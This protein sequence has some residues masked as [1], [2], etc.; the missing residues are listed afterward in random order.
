MADI[1]AAQNGKL[2]V[3]ASGV[4]PNSMKD[5]P[6]LSV[7]DNTAKIAVSAFNYYI[8]A[9]LVEADASTGIAVGSG[10]ISAAKYATIRLEI[11][12]AGTLTAGTKSSSH[13]TAAQA[14]AD[15]TDVTTDK[16]SVGY[17]LIKSATSTVTTLGT[18]NLSE[19]AAA[20][21]TA[22]ITFYEEFDRS[23]V[24]DFRGQVSMTNSVTTV[25]WVGQDIVPS[26][27]IATGMD[28]ELNISEMI[29]RPDSLRKF[30][31]AV[32]N[33]ADT[34]KGGGD[35]YSWEVNADLRP[36]PLQLLFD[37]TDSETGLRKQIYCPQGKAMQIPMT[38]GS[39]DFVVHDVG[40]KL[41]IDSNR[42]FFYFYQA[43]A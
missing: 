36:V 27:S 43:K 21:A 3:A 17:Y 33:P 10:T 42:K 8:D 24:A 22:M 34:M 41:F 28:T 23:Y 19:T 18:T 16:M 29:F 20:G 7:S 14:L 30:W 1:Y 9:S 31:G 15:L 2:F 4:V 40:F 6:T 38:F 25:D 12:E 35:A 32:H 37:F 26:G 39:K 5:M 11:S 13:T